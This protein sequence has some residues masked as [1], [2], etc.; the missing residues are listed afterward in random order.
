[1]STSSYSPFSCYLIFFLSATERSRNWDL[2]VTTP[3]TLPPK[4]KC[5]VNDRKHMLLLLSYWYNHSV[6]KCAWERL[7]LMMYLI[8]K[9]SIMKNWE[10]KHLREE[11]NT[12]YTSSGEMLKWMSMTSSIGAVPLRK[13]RPWL[14]ILAGNSL[15]FANFDY[16]SF[17]SNFLEFR[18]AITMKIHL[19]FASKPLT[20]IKEVLLDQVWF[21]F[22]KSFI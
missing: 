12:K 17:D 14:G 8:V 20:S 15:S 16:L 11:K 3:P 4:S 22:L 13:E 5:L 1:M 6:V 19:H 10:R 9:C 2:I 18:L 21:A 7:S